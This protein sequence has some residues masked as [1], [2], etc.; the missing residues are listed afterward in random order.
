[1]SSG[2][3]AASGGNADLATIANE[4]PAL[5]AQPLTFAGFWRRFAALLVDSL[6]LGLLGQLLAWKFA[7]HFMVMDGWERLIGLAI[8]LAYGGVFDSH[9]GGGQSPG[10]RLLGIRVVALDGSL[11]GVPK[12]MLRKLVFWAPFFLNGAITDPDLVLSVVGVLAAVIIFG[13]F[14]SLAYLSV[15]NRPTRRV[16]HDLV[17]GTCVVRAREGVAPEVGR[18]KSVHR[19]ILGGLL[20]LIAIVPMAVQKLLPAGLLEGVADLQQA[21]LERPGISEA[22]VM[23]GFTTGTKRETVTYVS[24]NLKVVDRGEW[25]DEHAES[26]ARFIIERYPEA[27]EKDFISIT[28]YRGYDLVIASGWESYSSSLRVDDLRSDQG[29]E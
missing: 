20:V 13:G 8:V 17:A 11:L 7:A 3:D 23:V 2:V 10:K 14:F 15:F 21:M 5:P 18:L 28:F 27:L 24:A 4:P 29:E 22:G 6:L 25:T 26:L 16:I 12:A 1:M 9:L 19:W